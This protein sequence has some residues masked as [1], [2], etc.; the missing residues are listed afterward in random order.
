MSSTPPPSPLAPGFRLDRYELICPI[1]EGGM[2][3]VWIARQTGRHGFQKLVAIKTI[4]PKF[5]ADAR[6]QRMFQ[7]EAR[8]ASRIEHV[9][10]AQILDVGEQHD[11]TYL[12]ME[13]VDGDA[14]SRLDRALEKT[15]AR[16]PL[17]V[18]LRI[19]ADV[20]G[21][22]HAAHELRDDAG[23]LLGVV[24]R[25]VS[26]PNV[27]VSTIG[28]AKL[29]DFGIAKARDRL[30]NDTRTDQLK[31]KVAYMAPEQ[32]LGGAIDRRADIWAV[33]AV[34]YHLFA[35][36]PP[37]EGDND[38]QKLFALA[39]GAPPA[40]LPSTV[41]APVAAVVSRALAHRAYDRF[42]TAAEMQQALERAM[43]EVGAST[44]TTAVA[45]FL[46]RHASDRAQ[47]RKESIALGLKACEER[48]KISAIMKLNADASGPSPS[49]SAGPVPVPEPVAA[50]TEVGE[51]SAPGTLGLATITMNVPLRQRPMKFAVLGV[52]A[53][54]GIGIAGMLLAMR[55][56]GGEPELSASP[57]VA[58]SSEPAS[59]VTKG[60][61]AGE[62]ASPGSSP[63]ASPV[64]PSS[65]PVVEP[66]ATPAA[67]MPS[68]SPPSPRSPSAHPRSAPRTTQ[69]RQREDYG[70]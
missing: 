59:V 38:V 49:S 43:V 30:A 52:A 25:D 13:Y 55:G 23:Q 29:I 65:A 32:A 46:Q 1:A 67:S 22:L 17:G 15:G 2:A 26:P 7:D 9:N 42:E 40:P 4:L 41:P 68:S 57:S 16:I 24:H 70:F 62:I 20:C 37:F 5:A 47:K 63:S 60:S 10:V 45:E 6:F 34:L 3:S 8:I 48:E 54:L 14:L 44:T 58:A 12:V 31:G 64:A 27:L 39:K 33:G 35:G 28:V 36:R 69:Q 50:I 66:A 21:G 18:V 11:V 56:G 53:G 61:A 51:K 19:M